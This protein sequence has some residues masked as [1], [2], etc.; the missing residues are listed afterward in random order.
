[1]KSV[2]SGARIL[3]KT[4]KNLVFDALSDPKSVASVCKICARMSRF[5]VAP[6]MR[7]KKA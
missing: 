2:A 4:V 6:L 5:L 7:S 3:Q 1:V